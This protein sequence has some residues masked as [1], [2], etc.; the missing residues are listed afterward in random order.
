MPKQQQQNPDLE[1]DQMIRQVPLHH[2]PQTRTPS[3]SSPNSTL[4]MPNVPSYPQL[5]PI[6]LSRQLS[7]LSNP[8]F[9][10]EDDPTSALP[11]GDSAAAHR[12]PAL[13]SAVL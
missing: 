5:P 2:R 13:F 11:S 6:S 8:A 7:G 10:I 1:M 9:H 4:E 12:H 3:P